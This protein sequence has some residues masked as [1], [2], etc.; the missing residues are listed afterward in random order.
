MYILSKWLNIQYVPLALKSP[1][2][3]SMRPIKNEGRYLGTISF[4]ISSSGYFYTCY[5]K[6]SLDQSYGVLQFHIGINNMVIQGHLSKSN[7]IYTGWS[8]H[9]KSQ[10]G[11]ALLAIAIATR[12]IGYIS[13]HSLGIQGSAASSSSS[14]SSSS[15]MLLSLGDLDWLSISACRNTTIGVTSVLSQHISFSIFLLIQRHP[16]GFKLFTFGPFKHI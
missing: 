16:T 2:Q 9:N 8:N 6:T 1:K 13:H 7:I 14:S 12:S 3:W 5:D 4:R 15:S 11:S 10:S